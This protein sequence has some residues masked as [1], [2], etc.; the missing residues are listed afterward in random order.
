MNVSLKC[1]GLSLIS[2][3]FYSYFISIHFPSSPYKKMFF[4]KNLNIVA[5]CYERENKKFT[6]FR[7]YTINKSKNNSETSIYT[8]LA[9]KYL[10]FNR[11]KT[12]RRRTGYFRFKDTSLFEWIFLAQICGRFLEVGNMRSCW[13]KL[14]A[15]QIIFKFIQG[16]QFLQM[17][18]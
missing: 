4:S 7:I 15:Y 1:T 5:W 2:F 6:D 17:V 9:L 14:T 10:V 13:I 18:F 16:C 3:D 12:P 8:F 11:K